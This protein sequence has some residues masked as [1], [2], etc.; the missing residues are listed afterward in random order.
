MDCGATTPV[1]HEVA[2]AML[3]YL[4]EHFGNPS[5]IHDFGV[6]AR[7]GVERARR[8]VAE[9]IN[10]PTPES[11]VFTGSGTEADN[12]AIRGCLGV[13][14]DRLHVITVAVEHKA[15]LKSCEELR[16]QGYDVTFLPVDGDCR[17]PVQE[18]A[19]ALR[20]DTLLVSV[21]FVNNESGVV[22]PIGEIASLCRERNVLFHTDAVQA[23]G[24]VPVDV[25]A[26]DVDLLAMSA[27]KIYGPKGV[28][29]LYI[30]PGLRLK[31][32]IVGGGQENGLRAG[33][34]NVAGIVGFGRAAELARRR[35]ESDH[36]RLTGL[37]RYFWDSIRERIPEVRLN[38]HPDHRIAGMLNVCFQGISGQR[39]VTEMA[40]RGVA[41]SAGSAC[42]SVGTSHS[43][44]LLGMGLSENDAFG[45]VRISL[46]RSNDA[47][48]IDAV[49][50]FLPDLIERL[51]GELSEAETG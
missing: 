18:V 14:P 12:L 37:R 6:E 32:L 1:A 49:M 47:D 46:G 11:I 42:N 31:S 36:E 16:A 26:L 39:L 15:V 4:T 24:K 7:L 3:P 27:H 40:A 44:V 48:Q 45:S 28:G 2:E 20:P 35:L 21:M 23:V 17:V 30:R 51:R 13:H 33:T 19:R 43:H 41:I 25:Q 5:S 38:G 34:E 9:L 50:K 8:Q 29:A 22:Q 10:A